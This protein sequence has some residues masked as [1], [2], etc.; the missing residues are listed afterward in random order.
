HEANGWRIGQA[1]S[2]V[3][4]GQIAR[5]LC[6]D[7]L[8]NLRRE[9]QNRSRPGLIVATRGLPIAAHAHE[10]SGRDDPL[11]CAPLPAACGRARPPDA[12]EHLAAEEGCASRAKSVDPV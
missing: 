9:S 12:R 5:E 2:M 10:A 4:Q 8:T 11:R 6:D 1:F 7:F 3:A